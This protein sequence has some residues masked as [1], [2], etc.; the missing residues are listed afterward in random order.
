M[1]NMIGGEFVTANLSRAVVE[2]VRQSEVREW[3]YELAGFV[4][5]ESAWEVEAC[6]NEPPSDISQVKD[7]L[8][9]RLA[10][11]LRDAEYQG[12]LR[13]VIVWFGKT[14][15]AEISAKG[16]STFGSFLD[17][18][19]R[20][21]QLGQTDT[22]LDIIFD[23]IDEMLLAGEFDRVNQVLVDTHADNYSVDL[24]LGILTA[25]LPAKDRFSSRPEFFRRVA[26]TLQ[27]RGELKDG[28]LIGLD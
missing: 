19:K 6:T 22:A 13:D 28:L 1:R 3:R 17:H 14:V 9:S 5:Y 23:Q 24:L 18:A 11:I 10:S 8:I 21:D 26:H 4:D 2:N 15:A 7:L 25:T 20:L 27:S 12:K 16:E